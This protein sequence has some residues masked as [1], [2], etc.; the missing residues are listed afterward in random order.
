MRD[1]KPMTVIN[2]RLRTEPDMQIFL[3]ASAA[4]CTRGS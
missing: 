1:G 2:A 3:E 4:R